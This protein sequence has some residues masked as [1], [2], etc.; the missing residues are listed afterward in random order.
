MGQGVR[1]PSNPPV[2]VRVRWL[3]RTGLGIGLALLFRD[4]SHDNAT[5]VMPAFLATLGRPRFGSS[6][7]AA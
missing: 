5:T 6:C 2:K 1:A 4:W 3:N 7:S